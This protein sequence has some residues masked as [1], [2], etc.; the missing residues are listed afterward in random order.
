MRLTLLFLHISGGVLGLLSGTL[1][2]I[3]RKGSRGHR[4]AGDVFVVAM[5]TMGACGS[6]LALMKHQTGNVFGGLITFYMITTAWLAGRR[7]NGV[8][9][10]DWAALAMALVLGGSMITLGVRVVNGIDAKQEGVPVAMY[11]V[12]GSIPLLAGVGDARVLVRGGISGTA[13]LARHLWRMLFGLFIASGSFF[14]GQQQVFP[15]AWRGSPVW[16]VPALLP[17]ALLIFWLIRVRVG[18][19]Y[20]DAGNGRAELSAVR[21]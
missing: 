4:L 8:S 6:T 3:Y 12:M 15:A 9:A 21:V 17:L 5:L 19:R 14:L 7:R 13:R 18:K 2:M 16:F 11:F 1:A 10:L 20:T